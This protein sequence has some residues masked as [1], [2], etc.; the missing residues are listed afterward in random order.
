MIAERL[1]VASLLIAVAGCTGGGREKA[2][3][4]SS[5]AALQQRGESAMG[6]NQ[7]TSQHVF[8][9]LPTGGRIVLQRKESD[10]IGEAAI[11]AHMRTISCVH[12]RGLS[13]CL[14]SFTPWVTCREHP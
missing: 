1:L 13:L 10:S 14:V 5:F 8:E 7:Y 3:S 9:P 11:R 6:V 2:R 12:E 4:D